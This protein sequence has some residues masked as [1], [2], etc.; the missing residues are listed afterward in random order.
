MLTRTTHR[1]LQRTRFAKTRS[2]LSGVPL[3]TDLLPQEVILFTAD[4]PDARNSH[5]SAIVPKPWSKRVLSSF[6][7][8]V[9]LFS[10]VVALVIFVP[11]AYY[12]VFPADVI[13]I[14][15]P[16]QGTAFGGSFEDPI[17]EVPEEKAYLPPKD[18]SLPEGDW[19]IIPRIGV[20]TQL[21]E[22]ENPEEALAKGVWQVPDFGDPGDR[23]E[24]MIL[25]A[26][27]YGWQ[28]WWKDDYWR[29]HSFNLLPDTEPGDRIEVISDQRKW[30]YEIYAGEEGEDITDYN[31]DLILYTCKF[32]QGPLRHFRYAR[33]IDPTQNTQ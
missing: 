24:P 2:F 29:Y 31:A 12:L 32:L 4:A 26:H 22:T 28:W 19:L 8:I 7:S 30:V 9:S 20:R 18:E 3:K 13:E 1:Q 21:R 11:A 6:L 16:E 5:K 15:P 23:E 33:L 14:T 27:R 25:A 10:I 17:V